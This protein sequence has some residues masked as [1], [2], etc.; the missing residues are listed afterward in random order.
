MKK[1][2][3]LAVSELSGMFAAGNVKILRYFREAGR[4]PA[5]FTT[6]A[7]APFGRVDTPGPMSGAFSGDT[8]HPDHTALRRRRNPAPGRNAP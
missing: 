1:H 7:R 3:T 2:N 5:L 4:V 8:A 6:H